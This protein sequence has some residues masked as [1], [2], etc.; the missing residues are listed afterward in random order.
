MHWPKEDEIRWVEHEL[1]RA[2]FGDE[3]QKSP[4][5]GNPI[6]LEIWLA[7]EKEKKSWKQIGDQFFKKAK[8]KP[9]ARRSEARRSCGRV[10]RYMDNPNAREFQVHHLKR[11]VT[12]TFGVSVEDFRFFVL[13]GRLPKSKEKPD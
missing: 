12:E 3:W 11:L 2:R 10:Q 8:M 6:D 9:E 5:A 4:I 7:R 13:H 1:M